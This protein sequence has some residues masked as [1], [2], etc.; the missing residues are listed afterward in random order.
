MLRGNV[1]HYI[2]S[3]TRRRRQTSQTLNT[4]YMSALFGYK[5]R[6][7]NRKG[8]SFWKFLTTKFIHTHKYNN[9]GHSE[10]IRRDAADVTYRHFTWYLDVVGNVPKGKCN[11]LN[12]FSR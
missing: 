5:H 1:F 2:L 10:Q 8:S 12:P 6:Y 4:K 3:Q 7:K 11:Y 9:T